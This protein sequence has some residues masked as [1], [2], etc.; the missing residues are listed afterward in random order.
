MSIGLKLILALV[1]NATALLVGYFSVREHQLPP[2]RWIRPL[3]VIVAGLTAIWMG[4]FIYFC[5]DPWVYVGSDDYGWHRDFRLDFVGGIFISAFA[6]LVF[7]PI[8][9][10]PVIVISIAILRRSQVPGKP[11]RVEGR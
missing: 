8:V 11:L 9:I 5:Y 7:S 10:A 2:R 4:F 3:V 6:T 1:V